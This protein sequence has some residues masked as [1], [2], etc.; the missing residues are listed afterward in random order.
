MIR[1]VR[2][3]SRIRRFGNSPR[4]LVLLPIGNL[5]FDRELGAL[6]E[7][8][9]LATAH[10]EGRHEIFEHRPAPGKERGGASH[11]RHRTPERVPV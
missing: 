3:E 10:E 1:V 5:G 9:S 4:C 11:A 8:R 2:V 7:Q 6:L